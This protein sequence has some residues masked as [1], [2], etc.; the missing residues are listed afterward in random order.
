VVQSQ[1]S[2]QFH[3]THLEKPFTKI[4][5]VEWL[6]VKTLEFKLQYCKK[7]KSKQGEIPHAIGL[8]NGFVAMTLKAQTTKTKL[9]KLDYI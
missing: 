6:K 9:D 4:G 1:L 2:K 3:K 5:R 7:K 8:G